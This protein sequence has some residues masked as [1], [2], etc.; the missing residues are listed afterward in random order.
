MD[1]FIFTLFTADELCYLL[2]TCALYNYINYE[3]AFAH[4]DSR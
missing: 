3:I 1:E 4:G 2:I